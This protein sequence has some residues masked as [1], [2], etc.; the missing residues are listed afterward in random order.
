[1]MGV[2]LDHQIPIHAHGVG[3]ALTNL[4]LDEKASKQESSMNAIHA[5]STVEVEFASGIKQSLKTLGISR[6]KY[7]DRSMCKLH[8][9]QYSAGIGSGAQKVTAKQPNEN[10]FQTLTTI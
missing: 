8:S 7:F 10:A 1:M 2:S 5:C 3:D 6:Q 4:L 9:W